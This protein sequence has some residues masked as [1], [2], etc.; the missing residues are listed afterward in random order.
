MREKGGGGGG[1]LLGTTNNCIAHSMSINRGESWSD[2]GTARGNGGELF[3]C[4]NVFLVHS[5]TA[6]T[7]QPITDLVFLF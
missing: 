6:S 2:S 5:A 3:S 7:N 1:Y 4:F